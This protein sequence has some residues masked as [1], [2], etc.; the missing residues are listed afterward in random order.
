MEPYLVTS[1]IKSTLI[2]VWPYLELVFKA[3]DHLAFCLLVQTVDGHPQVWSSNLSVSTND[4]LT[5]GIMNEHILGLENS[6][7]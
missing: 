6:V 5:Q 2:Q 4:K 7:E 3:R 1:D